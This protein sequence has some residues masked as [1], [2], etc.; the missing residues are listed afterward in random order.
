MGTLAAPAVG[1]R[2]RFTRSSIFGAGQGSRY[3]RS[4]RHNESM[5]P[6][7]SRA[8]RTL[9]QRLGGYD[10][11]AAIVDE[12]FAM[13][14]ADP[15]FVRFGLG[16][17]TDSQ[18]RARQFLV[19]Q[20][21]AL[22]GGPCFYLG[23]DMKTAHAGLGITAQEWDANMRHTVAALEKHGIADPERSEFLSLF[24]RYKGDIVES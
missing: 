9:Y 4:L 5:Q 3:T 17:S 7:S 2:H 6:D 20:I 16:R 19:D 24:T 22:S 8:E 13:L 23:R 18:Q 15:A 10:V 12:L 14:R 21:C 1:L 11:I